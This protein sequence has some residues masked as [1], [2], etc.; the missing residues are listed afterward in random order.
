M[1][2]VISWKVAPGKYA[3]ITKPNGRYIQ[4]R[5]T[6]SAQLNEMA[7]TVKGWTKEQYTSAFGEMQTEV[8]NIYGNLEGSAAD[9]YNLSELNSASIVLLA[10]DDAGTANVGDDG[11]LFLG[12]EDYRKLIDDIERQFNAQR[13]ILANELNR[14]KDSIEHNAGVDL[15]DAMNE[16]NAT[17]ERLADAERRLSDAAKNA[18]DA[19]DALRSLG[20]GELTPEQMED[21]LSKLSAM[22]DWLGDMGDKIKAFLTEYDAVLGNLG[23]MG[24]AYDV[25][26]G[27]LSLMLSNINTISGTVGTVTRT[28]NAQRGEISDLTTY[29]E[30]LSGTTTRLERKMSGMQGLIQDTAE[31]MS[32]EYINIVDRKID[33]K[34]AE[35]VDSISHS[36]SADVTS[37]RQSLNGLS[38][39]VKTQI[40][41]LDTLNGNITSI[42]TELNGLEGRISTAMT[43]ADSAL[44]EAMALRNE[45]NATDGSII[46]EIADLVI[47]KDENGIPIYYWIGNGEENKIRVYITDRKDEL[48]NTIYTANSDGTGTEYT[49]D[50]MPSYMTRMISYIM[51]NLDSISMQVTSGS[52]LAALKLSVTEDGSLIYLNA[53]RVVID[54]DV[55]AD[56][57]ES[58]AGNIG[59]VHIGAGMISAATDGNKWALTSA[60][61]LEATS[62]KIQGSISATSGYF[63]GDIYADTLTLGNNSIQDYITGR[64]NDAALS[65]TSGYSKDD[66]ISF[67]SGYVE[68]RDF[69]EGDALNGYVTEDGL[70]RWAESQ[71][72]ITSAY[73]QSVL[74][75]IEGAEISWAS[76][77]TE[78]GSGGTRHT[79][80]IGGHEYT[81]DTYDMKNAILLDTVI[82]GTSGDTEYKFLVDKNGLLQA[83]NAIIYGKVYASEGWF[84]GMIEAGEGKIGNIYIT[85]SGFSGTNLNITNNYFFSDNVTI[86]GSISADSGYFKG[87]IYADNGYFKGNVTSAKIYGSEI[88][89]SKILI[90]GKYRGEHIYFYFTEGDI[91]NGNLGII[92]NVTQMLEDDVTFQFYSEDSVHDFQT[93]EVAIERGSTSGVCYLDEHP[94]I[95]ADYEDM[96][97][98][99]KLAANRG[100]IMNSQIYDRLCNFDIVFS[101]KRTTVDFDYLDASELDG[102]VIYDPKAGTESSQSQYFEVKENGQ[103]TVQNAIINGDITMNSGN[104]IVMYNSGGVQ[105]FLLSSDKVLLDNVST[106]YAL[107]KKIVYSETYGYYENRGYSSYDDDGF[108]STTWTIATKKTSDLFTTFPVIYL[109]LMKD[110]RNGYG[111]GEGT[112]RVYWNGSEIAKFSGTTD[113]IIAPSTATTKAFNLQPYLSARQA[114]SGVLKIT[115][116][117]ETEAGASAPGYRG[118]ESYGYGRVE[119]YANEGITLQ[120]TTTSVDN[121]FIVGSNGIQMMLDGGSN[122]TFGIIDGQPR[123]HCELRDNGAIVSGIDIDSTEGVRYYPKGGNQYKQLL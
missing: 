26:Q 91:G 37:I 7:S 35:I 44:T 38:A 62:A 13:E 12:D 106:T 11:S 123:F 14:I 119:F 53:D 45:W 32:G 103:M 46:Q 105:S 24:I 22:K 9:Y 43:R 59:G 41:R 80:I 58:K 23:S 39:T 5:I 107:R 70:R 18:Q 95:L 104:S 27:L 51:Q 65:G 122:L 89:G 2:S 83:N 69:L 29:Y 33:A 16:I 60:G 73:V 57:L 82:S 54:S 4:G 34:A 17:K 1:A 84:K 96:H 99:N 40:A 21:I 66:I 102:F 72:G 10:G 77:T 75:T 79:L 94:E 42:N 114:E 110:N 76:A 56:S 15:T 20:G 36:S 81:W 117:G 92:G 68:S 85:N 108:Q 109:K 28:M 78:N 115:Y 64:I 71:S 90:D 19:L 112:V 55:I 63:K 50:V 121:K 113:E 25:S 111:Y 61:T 88:Y 86:K 116:E 47:E 87:D 93:M 98:Q 97:G 6:D 31:F 118:D 67:V 49:T 52:V 120:G 74:D 8:N 100:Y 48:G 3:Y 30:E 101:L